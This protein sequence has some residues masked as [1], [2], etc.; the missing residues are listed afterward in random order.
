MN[1]SPSFPSLL[2]YSWLLNWW[3]GLTIQSKCHNPQIPAKGFAITIQIQNW[4]DFGFFQSPNPN[5]STFG[6]LSPLATFRVRF[7]CFSPWH[8][9][10]NIHGRERVDFKLSTLSASSVCTISPCK[11]S[12]TRSFYR[13]TR[14]C[15]PS[16]SFSCVAAMMARWKFGLPACGQVAP[17]HA[18][19][20]SPVR[21]TAYACSLEA[22]LIMIHAR[23]QQF[24]PKR[25]TRS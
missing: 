16:C 12:S 13:S 3:I 7:P 5:P 17:S 14:L 1:Q 9:H 24:R 11:K 22:V 25:K 6:M 15:P 18:K 4:K 10:I 20:C 23:C 21:V 19:E 8:L 2:S